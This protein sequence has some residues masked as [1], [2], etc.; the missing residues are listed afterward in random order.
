MLNF[1]S[2][3]VISLCS[4]SFASLCEKVENFLRPVETLR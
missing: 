3:P 4:T 1:E 2:V